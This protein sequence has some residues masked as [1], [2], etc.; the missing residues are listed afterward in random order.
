M[1][2]VGSVFNSRRTICRAKRHR[3][4][5]QFTLHFGVQLFERLGEIVEHALEPLDLRAH[6]GAARL[7]TL[8][9]PLLEGFLVCLGLQI[10]EAAHGGHGWNR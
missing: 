8:G 5:Q 1:I 7:T 10:G 6:L 4:R 9:E 3:E 2:C